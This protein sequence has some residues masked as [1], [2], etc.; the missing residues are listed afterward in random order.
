MLRVQNL[1][2]VAGTEMGPSSPRSKEGHFWAG[3]RGSQDNSGWEEP[4]DSLDQ[5]L[6]KA[7]TALRSGQVAWA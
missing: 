7:R 4:Q 6:L 2:V 1:V 3:I 5:P